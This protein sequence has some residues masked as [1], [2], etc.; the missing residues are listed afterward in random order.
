MPGGDGTGPLGRGPVTGRGMGF[1]TGD[2]VG[3]R[4]GGFGRGLGYGYGLGSGLGYG[5]R[6]GFGRFFIDETVGMTEKE[7]L[8]EQK[9]LLQRRLDLISK[10]LETLSEKDE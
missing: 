1:C 7:F 4:G 3:R 2:Y 10:E 5:C 6:R 8:T 9:E